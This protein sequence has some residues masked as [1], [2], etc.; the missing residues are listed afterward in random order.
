MSYIM[1]C[2]VIL[3]LSDDCV[4]ICYYCLLRVEEFGAL[5]EASDVYSFGVFLLEL[6]TGREAAH[7]FSPES[8]ESLAQWVM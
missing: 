4:I 2:R 5:S 6:I 1:G 7:F 3:I 8:D